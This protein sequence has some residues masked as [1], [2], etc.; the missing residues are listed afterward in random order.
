ML[1]LWEAGNRS[2]SRAARSARAKPG[3]RT[4]AALFYRVLNRLAGIHIPQNT[5]ICLIDRRVTDELNRM[6]DTNRF[7]AA[8]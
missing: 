6:G 2:S 7:C 3:S 5:A 8:W 4:S 1:G